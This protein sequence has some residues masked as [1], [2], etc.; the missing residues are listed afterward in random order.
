MQPG[1]RAQNE[2][3]LEE[4]REKEEEVVAVV[5]VRRR[6][7]GFTASNMASAATPSSCRNWIGARAEDRRHRLNNMAALGAGQVSC[8]EIHRQLTVNGQLG[9][10]ST[11]RAR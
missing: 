4:A 11:W 1:L 2:E 6:K 10:C 5:E 3:E 7:G 8:R 9:N